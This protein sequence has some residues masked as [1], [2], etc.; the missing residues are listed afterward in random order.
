MNQ[1]EYVLLEP[2][3]PGTSEEILRQINIDNKDF[4]FV[5]DNKYI[6]NDPKP[7]F[8]RIDQRKE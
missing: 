7:L 3:L 5:D 4:S 8:L 2:F 6:L 1:F